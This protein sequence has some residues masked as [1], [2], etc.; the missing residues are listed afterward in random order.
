MGAGRAVRVGGQGICH[1]DGDPFVGP[2]SMSRSLLP[3]RES[4]YSRQRAVLGAW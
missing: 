3:E 2:Q 1:R 4:G